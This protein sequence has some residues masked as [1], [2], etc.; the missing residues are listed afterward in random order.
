MSNPVAFIVQDAQTGDAVIAAYNSGK[1]AIPVWLGTDNTTLTFVSSFAPEA[2]WQDGKCTRRMYL[3]EDG[4]LV[5]GEE[6][7]VPGSARKTTGRITLRIRVTE[8]FEDASVDACKT[9]LQVMSNCY[10]DIAQCGGAD[11]AANAG[12]QSVVQ[13]L[14]GPYI[15]AGTMTAADIANATNIAYEVQYQ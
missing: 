1:S 2:I 10:Q 4:A 11:S 14:F 3:E 6:V 8:V 9:T 5:P 7:A 13:E 12:L 15:E